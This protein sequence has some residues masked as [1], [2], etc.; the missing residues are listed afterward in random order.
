VRQSET[1]FRVLT[2]IFREVQRTLGGRSRE[3]VVVRSPINLIDPID[4]IDQAQISLVFAETCRCALNGPAQ[5]LEWD[6][7]TRMPRWTRTLVGFVLVIGVMPQA[8][9]L[10]TMTRYRPRKVCM[11][12]RQEDVSLK[13]ADSNG[14]VSGTPGRLGKAPRWATE[15]TQCIVASCPHPHAPSKEP[16]RGNGNHRPGRKETDGDMNKIDLRK[17]Q[18]NVGPKLNGSISNF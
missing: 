10:D 7:S 8:Q 18:G 4:S 5:A 13:V 12:E 16:T 2:Q 17:I 1:T 3:S 9:A 6:G 15:R 14:V 11:L